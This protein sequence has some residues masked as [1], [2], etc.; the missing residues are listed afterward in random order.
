MVRSTVDWKYRGLTI[1]EKTAC[2]VSPARGLPTGRAHTDRL[3]R[4]VT[5]RPR[6]SYGREITVEEI[7]ILP[8]SQRRELL[9]RR[10]LPLSILPSCRHTV[11]GLR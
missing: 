7:D 6:S 10:V 1:P 4:D 3:S 9:V 8:Y 2:D 11:C 5:G